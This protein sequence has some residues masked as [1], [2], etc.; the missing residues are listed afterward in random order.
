LPG[1]MR[2]GAGH[3]ISFRINGQPVPGGDLDL[4]L[5]RPKPEPAGA[6]QQVNRHVCTGWLRDMAAPDKVLTAEILSGDRVIGRGPACHPVTAKT[7]ADIPEGGMAPPPG[8]TGSFEIRLPKRFADGTPHALRLRIAGT[9]QSLAEAE[10]ADSAFA[11]GDGAQAPQKPPRAVLEDMMHRGP[12]WLGAH[13]IETLPI[14]RHLD[15]VRAALVQRHA[16]RPADEQVSI[17]MPVFNGAGTIGAAIRSVLAQSH[18]RWELLIVDDA[19]T[20]DTREILEGLLEQVGDDRIRLIRQA[21]NGG[22]SA[23]RNAALAQARGAIIAYLDCD[24]LWDPDY[25]AVMTGEMAGTGTDP[26]RQAAYCGHLIGQTGMTD[27]PEDPAA[28]RHAAP[29]DPDEAPAPPTEILGLGLRSF[30]MAMAENQRLIRLSGFV[31]RRA[32]LER[33]GGFDPAMRRFGDRAL[34]LRYAAEEIPH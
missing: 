28:M 21:H 14:W 12:L 17:V 5:D 18:D 30:H 23:A 8:A 6:I 2:D 27:H 4:F 26:A 20:D 29:Q 22:V 34:I 11:R 33:L 15:M 1:W 7:A 3:R 32:L 24:D 31:H 16:A 25:L 10:L 13:P 9:S 19:S